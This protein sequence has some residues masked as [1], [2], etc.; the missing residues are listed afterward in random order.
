MKSLD[1]SALLNDLTEIITENKTICYQSAPNALY[2]NAHS[3]M[4][5]VKKE[6]VQKT[7][8][9]FFDRYEITFKPSNYYL[10]SDNN[11][12][13]VNP[14]E[15]NHDTM[16]PLLNKAELLEELI[17]KVWV[18]EEADMFFACVVEECGIITRCLSFR[19]EDERDA[20]LW[21]AS[22]IEDEVCRSLR[23][24]IIYR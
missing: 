7:L 6:E 22:I 1:K 9:K 17:A 21:G 19:T 14:P 11:A 20:A 15:V 2:E 23:E 12:V 4:H 8:I 18:E 5:R 3:A 13:I 16:I 10:C 24:V